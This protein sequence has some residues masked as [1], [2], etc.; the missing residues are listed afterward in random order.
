MMQV[1]ERL[2]RKRGQTKPE[3]PR[4]RFRRASVLASTVL[5]ASLLLPAAVKAGENPIPEELKGQAVVFE[6]KPKA[7]KTR[8]IIFGEDDTIKIQTIGRKYD[9]CNVETWKASENP[10]KTGKIIEEIEDGL[11]EKKVGKIR[12]VQLVEKKA[13]K[14]EDMPEEYSKYLKGH[15]ARLCRDKEET[16]SVAE[17]KTEP[18]KGSGILKAGNRM[19]T[20]EKI[21]YGIVAAIVLVTATTAGLL[22][23]FS[24]KR[25]K[26]NVRK[27]DI[28][29]RDEEF[30]CWA[31][32]IDE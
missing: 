2:D 29:D 20:G 8:I 23:R 13:A 21:V 26:E 24:P 19:S 25:R 18:D 5:S 17:E 15:V 14:L 31:S 3:L 32:D 30:T 4:N 11:E 22:R 16:I 7:G 6:P 10:E 27:R 9:W 12:G 28:K 1:R